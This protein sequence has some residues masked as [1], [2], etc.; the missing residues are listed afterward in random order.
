MQAPR[1]LTYGVLLYRVWGPEWL[2]EGWLLRDLVKKL[3][4]KLGDSAAGPRY[5]L[6][7]PKMGY[8][9]AISETAEKS[10]LS[11]STISPHA[12]DVACPPP[13]IV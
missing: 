5:I 12:D 10:S 2:G 8:R 11:M 6:T 4:R 3:R 7:G 9:L 13:M 1:V